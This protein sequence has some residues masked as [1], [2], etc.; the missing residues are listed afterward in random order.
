VASSWKLSKLKLVTTLLSGV[1]ATL[2]SL[3]RWLPTEPMAACAVG[4]EGEVR[5]RDKGTP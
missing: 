1:A 5:G 2:G 4:K 3:R